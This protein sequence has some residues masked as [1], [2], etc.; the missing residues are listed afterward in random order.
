[1]NVL[2]IVSQ[3]GT[4]Q[5]HILAMLGQEDIQNDIISFLRYSL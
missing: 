2:L 5:W 1:M 3:F 4:F